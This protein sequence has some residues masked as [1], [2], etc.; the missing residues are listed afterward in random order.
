MVIQGTYPSSLGTG[1]KT[2]IAANDPRNGLI[3]TCPSRRLLAGVDSAD[4]ASSRS[5]IIIS[6]NNDDFSVTSSDMSALVRD[7]L[8]GAIIVPGPGRELQGGVSSSTGGTGLCIYGQVSLPSSVTSDVDTKTEAVRVNLV[9]A[10]STSLTTSNAFQRTSIAMVAAS[11]INAANWTV[12]SG[13]IASIPVVTNSGG[14]GDSGWNLGGLS[15]YQIL[16]YAAAGIAGL[17]LLVS[18]IVF[19]YRSG[20]GPKPPVA[21]AAAGGGQAAAA[22]GRQARNSRQGG[23]GGRGG[24]AVS[25]VDVPTYMPQ[26]AQPYAA[27]YYG[28]PMPVG[29]AIYVDQNGVPIAPYAPAVYGAPAA[30]YVLSPYGAGALAYGVPPGT[31]AVAVDAQGGGYY[32]YA[33]PPSQQQQQQGGQRARRVSEAALGGAADPRLG[34]SAS[35][36]LPYTIAQYRNPSVRQMAVGGSSGSGGGGGGNAQQARRAKGGASS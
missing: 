35:E 20:Q 25:V 26:H 23:G 18:C 1:Y 17:L 24:G 21:A 32:T 34:A 29:A 10:F 5:S 2:T 16:I 13:Y 14:G 36:P 6:R 12:Y 4:G 11:G 9:Q 30:G 22:N 3:G 31:A 15:L 8:A 27:A 33:E 7:S 28:Q 19:F